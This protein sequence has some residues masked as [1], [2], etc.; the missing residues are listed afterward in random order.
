[1]PFDHITVHHEPLRLAQRIDRTAGH[2]ERVQH[3][4]A[5][6]RSDIPSPLH[7]TLPQGT[8]GQCQVDSVAERKFPE[9]N[10]YQKQ[11]LFAQ[12]FPPP[13]GK[14]RHG[15]DRPGTITVRERIEG[16]QTGIAASD[17]QPGMHL[18]FCL[19]H[20]KQQKQQKCS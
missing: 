17:D 3:R 8:V 6:R 13:I 12:L 16:R 19:A 14:R 7:G 18:C 9:R 1:M 10:V 5:L 2:P 20:C 15:L 4:V 11:I